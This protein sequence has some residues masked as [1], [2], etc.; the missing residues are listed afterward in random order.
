MNRA[1]L[2]RVIKFLTLVAK[3]DV[4]KDRVRH[5]RVEEEG[6]KSPEEEEREESGE[7]SHEEEEREESRGRGERRVTKKRREKSHEEEE[8]EESRRRGE[9]QKRDLYTTFE[10][11]TKAFHTISHEE[12]RRIMAKF[13]CLGKFI[14]M[15]CQFRNG[16]LARDD[17][18]S[19]DAFPVTKGVKQG[20]A[21]GPMLFSMMFSTMPSDAFRDDEETSIKIR[22]GTHVRLFKLWRLQA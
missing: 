13:G 19:S 22:Y 15:V 18:D 5:R 7:K 2:G 16:M 21:L 14:S 3:T 9:E 17:G 20:C 1:D 6:E 10:D 12:V 8:R 11:V 4:N